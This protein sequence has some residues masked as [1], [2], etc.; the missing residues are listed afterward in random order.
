M[1]TLNKYTGTR[2]YH[3]R[4]LSAVLFG[5]LLVFGGPAAYAQ[6]AKLDLSQLDKL[7][8]KASSIKDVNLD[9]AM[10]KQIGSSQLNLAGPAGEFKDMASRLHGIYVRKYEFDK[11]GEYPQEDL[12]SLM[13]QLRSGGWTSMVRKENKKT[14]EIKG[15]Y[16][17][18]KGGET[19]G[20]AVVKVAPKEVS[21]VNI[22]GPINIG[23]LGG[24][25]GHPGSSK[26]QLQHRDQTN[27]PQD[28]K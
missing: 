2:K 3:S 26:P 17:M 25:G 18:N 12:D 27:P 6:N 14:G 20:M 8:S 10:L 16:L 5:G 11:P 4:L 19:V 13:K 15:V 1:K 24:L 22:V 7:A 28:L 9:G 23:E 21:I